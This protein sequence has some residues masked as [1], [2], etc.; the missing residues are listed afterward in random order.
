MRD[1]AS[2]IRA[3]EISVDGG[4]WRPAFPEDGIA[5]LPEES[6]RF[7]LKDSSADSVRVIQVRAFD[8]AGNVGAGRL[9]GGS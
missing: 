6:F 3:I 9:R 8:S 7:P 4:T 2:P 5:D 1:E